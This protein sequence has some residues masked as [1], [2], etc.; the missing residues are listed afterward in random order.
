MWFHSLVIINKAPIHILF[1]CHYV[2]D[3]FVS[4][5]EMTARHR[6]SEMYM[7]MQFWLIRSNS[8]PR[9]LEYLHSK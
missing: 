8:S 7:P 9:G 1:M 3:I 2:L 6:V 5:S 4:V